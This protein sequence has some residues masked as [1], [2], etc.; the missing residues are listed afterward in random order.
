[1][2]SITNTAPGYAGHSG[3]PNDDI[4]KFDA[5]LRLHNAAP[6]MYVALRRIGDR[7][8]NFPDPDAVEEDEVAEITVT[9]SDWR[10]IRT[11]IAKAEGRIDA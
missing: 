1:M 3:A 7:L 5:H 10:R 6:D 9:L 4:A 8:P 11:A 2:P